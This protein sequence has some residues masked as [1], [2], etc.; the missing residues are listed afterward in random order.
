MQHSRRR[1]LGGEDGGDLAIGF[2]CMDDQRQPRRLRRRDVGA[3]DAFL[4]IV[5]AQIVMKIEAC[6]ADADDARMGGKRDEPVGD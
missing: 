1:L 3:E 4:H 5:R 6:L 2:A